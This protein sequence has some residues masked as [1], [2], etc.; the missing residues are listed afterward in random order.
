MKLTKM[1]RVS[2]TALGCLLALISCRQ[3]PDAAS[4]PL[5]PVD[6]KVVNH[7]V[8]VLGHERCVLELVDPASGEKVKSIR[9]AQPPNGMAVDGATAYVAEGGPRGAVEVVD[10]ESGELKCSF[11]AGHTPMSPVVRE[12]KLYVACRFDSRVLEM[13]A[14]TGT[15]LNSWNVPREPVALAFFLRD[16]ER[17]TIS[18]M[19]EKVTKI[20][21]LKS[22]AML[23]SNVFFWIILFY[24]CVPGTPGWAAKNWLPTLFSESLSIDISVAGPMSTISIALSSL[25]GVLVGGYISDRWVLR[26]VRGR[27]YTGALGLGFIIPSL[28][29]IG[30][31]HSI[32]ALVLGTILFGVGF[33]MFDANNMPILCQFVSARYRATAY[34]IMNMCGVFAGAAITSILGESTDA[35]HLGRDFALLAVFVLIMLVILVTC[36][37][38]KTIDMKD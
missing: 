9:L 20:P 29:F 8:A 18:V 31:G 14:A 24:F 37:R 15:V 27:V 12:E 17:G 6:V 25:F 22:L 11:P 5:A 13:D 36:L 38:P 33:G 23:F 30:F 1:L 19:Q 26:N 2:A 4:G 21:V 3:E 32:F 16:K 34:G 7:L 10:L 28:L 35:G